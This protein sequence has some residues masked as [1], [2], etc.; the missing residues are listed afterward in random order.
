MELLYANETASDL[1]LMALAWL[2]GSTSFV[3]WRLARHRGRWWRLVL[4]S[5]PSGLFSALMLGLYLGRS[6]EPLGISLVVSL[7]GLAGMLEPAELRRYAVG[8]LERLLE[9]MGYRKG[10]GNGDT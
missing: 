5:L 10:G 7:S 6:A 3:V 2:S 9:S 1:A 4:A 8:A